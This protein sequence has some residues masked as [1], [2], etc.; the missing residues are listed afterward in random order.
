MK[1]ISICHGLIK[2]QTSLTNDTLIKVKSSS[3]RDRM[4]MNVLSR[5]VRLVVQWGI[6]NPSFMRNNPWKC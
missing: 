6:Y 4:H 5:K 1:A 3:F 2:I